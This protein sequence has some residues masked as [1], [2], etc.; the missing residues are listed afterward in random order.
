MLEMGS[1]Q[2]LV[3]EDEENG[4]DEEDSNPCLS[5]HMQQ[6]SI[7]DLKRKMESGE[8]S[9]ERKKKGLKLSIDMVGYLI[10]KG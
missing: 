2:Q 1:W 3:K 5:I 4:E 6:L 8:K 9:N 10:P 7:D